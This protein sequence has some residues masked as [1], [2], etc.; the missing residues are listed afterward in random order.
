MSGRDEILRR[1]LVYKA[2]QA[3]LHEALKA[4]GRVEHEAHGMVP[5]WRAAYATASGSTTEDH[6]EIT[7]EE[8][9]VAYIAGKYPTEVVTRTVTSVR[10]PEWLE[11]LLQGWADAGPEE[12]GA[13]LLDEE[14]TVIP[15]AKFVQGGEY[16]T[17]S[18]TPKP[19]ASSLIKKAVL[20]GV[21]I[22][23]WSMVEAIVKG[24]VDLSRPLRGGA[25]AG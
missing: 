7:D 25:D 23:D 4:E 16:I 14:G 8:K 6:V 20:R 21:T 22:G 3:A 15:G 10:N 12:D 5:T 11:R 9:L 18:V 13:T 2:A 1:Y 17:V 19:V 24:D